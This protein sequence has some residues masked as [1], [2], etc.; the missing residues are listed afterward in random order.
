M[1]GRVSRRQLL[2]GAGGLGA[3]AVVAAAAGMSPIHFDAIR[4]RF[5]NEAR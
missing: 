4:F 5:M 3:S 2:V 1:A